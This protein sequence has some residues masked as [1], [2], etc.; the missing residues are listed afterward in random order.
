MAIAWQTQLFY[1][2]FYGRK[3]CLDEATGKIAK[4]LF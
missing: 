3:K 2:L 1:G 4:N